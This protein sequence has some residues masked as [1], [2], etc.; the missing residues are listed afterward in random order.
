MKNALDMRL[1]LPMVTHTMSREEAGVQLSKRW[2]HDNHCATPHP[3]PMVAPQSSEA[4][5]LHKQSNVSYTRQNSGADYRKWAWTSCYNS[6]RQTWPRL[7]KPQSMAPSKMHPCPSLLLLPQPLHGHLCRIDSW[8]SRAK[9]N[10]F[11]MWEI[12]K[13]RHAIWPS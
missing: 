12:A 4:A 7:A 5:D 1:D 13:Q 11:K 9:S 8:A 10:C 6:H 3:H 2:F